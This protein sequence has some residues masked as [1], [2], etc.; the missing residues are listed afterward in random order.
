MQK[1]RCYLRCIKKGG[2]L[3][4]NSLIITGI[5]LLGGDANRIFLL[6]YHLRYKKRGGSFTHKYMILFEVYKRQRNKVSHQNIS[7]NKCCKEK[8]GH[9]VENSNKIPRSK[10]F[11]TKNV[12]KKR[13]AR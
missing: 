11:P 9:F 4:Q 5:K 6:R 13:V 7:Y 8:G 2:V 1:S 10:I 3:I 12:V